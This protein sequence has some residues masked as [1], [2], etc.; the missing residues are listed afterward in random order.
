M[1]KLCAYINVLLTN[2]NNDK[3]F[4]YFVDV[5]EPMLIGDMNYDEYVTYTM[6]TEG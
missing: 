3:M 5:I 4:Y 2:I 1:I 6:I